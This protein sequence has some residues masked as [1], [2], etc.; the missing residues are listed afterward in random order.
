MVSINLETTR[1]VGLVYAINKSDR[2]WTIESRNAI[3]VSI[4]LIGEVR[5]D[6]ATASR[7]STAA[8]PTIPISAPSPTAS[9]P[10]ISPPSTISPGA[11]P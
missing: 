9:A 7:S 8:S 10:A 1:T 3:E 5:D 4:E 11:A 6:P 2:Q